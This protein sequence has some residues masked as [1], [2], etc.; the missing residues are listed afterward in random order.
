MLQTIRSKLYLFLTILILGFIFI[1]YKVVE[2]SSHT[3]A[4]IKRM[5]LLGEI[6]FGAAMS[7]SELR[8]YSM[9]LKNERKNS[10]ESYTKKSVKALDS[11][12]EITRSTQNQAAINS[13][14]TDINK[15]YTDNLPRIEILTR[16]GMDVHED[17]FASRYPQEAA[18]MDRLARE[19]AIAFDAIIEKIYLLI[20]NMQTNN[21]ATVKSNTLFLKIIVGIIALVASFFFFILTRSIQNSVMRAKEACEQ[22]RHDKNLASS[23]E[24]GSKDEISQAMEAV[25]GL[26]GELSSAISNAKH[27]AIENA[28]VAQ[29]LS[30]TSLNIGKRTEDSAHEMD[31]AT[32]ATK[33]IA[34][35]LRTSEESS[36]KSGEVIESSSREVDAA[37]DD[38]LSISRDL[39]TIAVAQTDLASQLEELNQEAEQVKTVLTT[40]ADIADQTN[41]LALNAAIEAARA[42]EHGRGF[43]V[44]ADEVRKLAERTQRSLDESNATVTLIVQS[45][46]KAAS[47]MQKNTKEIERLSGRTK[48]TEV[49][50][51]ASVESIK[52]AKGM[53][54]KTVQDAKNGTKEAMSTLE[55]IETLNTLSADNA[56]SVEEIAAAAEHLSK[57]SENLSA[58]LAIFKTKL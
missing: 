54:L 57:L 21:L 30:S 6:E 3:E 37:A 51:N 46:D 55:R 25:N 48:K 17:T 13:I 35:L 19:S 53:A 36:A 29:E 5:L 39:Q 41:L 4:A 26:L 58:T 27:S 20:D 12:L 38:V 11:L 28:S 49:L 31:L 45:I 42:G 1:G 47:S 52:T 2:S 34:S 32:K 9:F 10:Y 15:W 24:I 50:M 23:I 18:L 56:R 40:I 22:I 14:K 33:R 16:F 7:M 8:G 43:A 44:V